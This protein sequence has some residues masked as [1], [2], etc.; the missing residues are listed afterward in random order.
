MQD[1]NYDLQINR[2]TQCSDRVR[3]ILEML[4]HQK[5]Q[6]FQTWLILC[7]VFNRQGLRNLESALD[8]SDFESR[9]ENNE[10]RNTKVHL[11]LPKFKFES[12]IPLVEILKNL[13]LTKMFE[14][15]ANFK[16]ISDIPLHVS[17]AVQKALIEVDETGTEAAAA[18]STF[19][20]GSKKSGTGGQKM[21]HFVADHPFLF[22]VR[23]LQTKLLL[24]QGRVALPTLLSP[25]G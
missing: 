11:E 17:D 7:F 16:G 8:D 6:F 2:M 10:S 25:S 5:F 15:D 13:G 18:S 24:F 21:E 9:I 4:A 14:A 12:E 3:Q 23:D 19:A 1:R 22:F 20:V